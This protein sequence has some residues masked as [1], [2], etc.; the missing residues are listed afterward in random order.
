MVDPDI[1]AHYALGFEAMRLFDDGHPRLEHV[2]TLELLDRHLPSP[3]GRVVDVG[4]GTGVYAVPLVERGFNVH[5]IEP[6]ETHVEHV[7]QTARRDGL[8][9]LTSDLGDARDLSGVAPLADAVLLLGPLYHLTE[10]SDRA[11]ALAEARR[12]VRP[13]GV[14]VAV[15]IS[16][17]ASLMDGL[18]RRILDDPIF[19]PIVQRDLESGQH[20]NP[21]VHNKPEYF[22]TAYFHR[23]DE[24]RDEALTAGLVDVALFA[25]EG[26]GWIVE[27]VTDLDSQL[28]AARAVET[29]PALLGASSH[30]MMIGYRPTSD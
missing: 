30:I 1:A 20:R 22:T 27:D 19:R 14:V 29:E 26:P 15:G 17:F 28:F 3:P 18:K 25:V 8:H 9:G 24:L 5:V 2:R 23:P 13:G 11:L 10:A 16:R 6:I 7:A 12:I 21:D 4:G